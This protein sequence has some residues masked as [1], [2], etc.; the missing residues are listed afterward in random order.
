MNFGANKRPFEVIK[1]GVFGETH[2]RSI[3]SSIHGKWYRKSW[4]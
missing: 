4:K 2:F 3:Y 1:E